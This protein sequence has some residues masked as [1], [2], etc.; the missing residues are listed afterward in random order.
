MLPEDWEPLYREILEDLGYDRSSDESSARMLKA[1][2]VN[3]DLILDDDVKMQKKATVFGCSDGL[4][5][6]ILA[7]A[8]RGTL[9]ASGSSVGRL[10]RIGVTPDIVVT[11]LDGDIGPQIDASK[12]G[13]VTFIHAHGDN[14][15]LIQR[16][17]QEFLGPVVLTTQSR[18]D[19]LVSN[20][21]GFT[22]G[23]RAVCIARHFGAEDILLLGF[24]FE[25]P[26]KKDGSDPRAKAKKLRWAKRIIF[27][28]NGPGV[29]I[30]MP[31]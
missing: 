28:C 9:I 29:S 20:Y 6:D 24:D 14:P 21:G 17:A 27:D 19:N 13:A 18:P 11:D 12:R 25:T 4:E 30:E 10:E 8:P 2:M 3:S 7:A 31:R 26:S 15:H 1:V 5:G 22:D 16:Y 23:D